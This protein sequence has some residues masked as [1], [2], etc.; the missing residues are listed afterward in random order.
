[1]NQIEADALQEN[2]KTFVDFSQQAKYSEEYWK[3]E[4]KVFDKLKIVSDKCMDTSTKLGAM[5]VLGDFSYNSN[6]KVE[7]MRQVGI[8]F[9]R[10]YL[11]F[12]VSEFS[13]EISDLLLKN[14]D[15]A[16]VVNKDG[17]ILA[18]KMYLE[19]RKPSLD[20]PDGCGTRHITAASFSTRKE[21][22]C[23]FTLSEETSIVRVWKDGIVIEQY[24]PSELKEIVKK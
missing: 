22:E 12:S 3:T 8:N 24:D 21:V 4:E 1:M 14:S 10:K 19:V 9:I 7:G 5:V 13:E 6:Y 18:T 15:G 17:Q 16:F 2:E 23:I 20:V 11:S